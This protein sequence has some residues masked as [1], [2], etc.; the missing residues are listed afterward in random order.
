MKVRN[1]E[2]FPVD[3]QMQVQNR[4]QVKLVSVQNTHSLKWKDPSFVMEP[5]LDN[6]M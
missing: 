2:S 5:L 1:F 6:S 4:A 3:D